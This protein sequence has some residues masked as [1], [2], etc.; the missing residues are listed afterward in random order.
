MT[1]LTC[2][3]ICPK[4]TTYNISFLYNIRTNSSFNQIIFLFNSINK[5]GLERG[6]ATL[7]V[8]ISYEKRN[9]VNKIKIKVV[10]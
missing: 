2:V 7:R 9:S 6:P 8:A 3:I 5:Q 10:G 4:L 1:S